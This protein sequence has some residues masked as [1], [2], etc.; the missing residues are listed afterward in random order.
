MIVPTS[1]ILK[2]CFILLAGYFNN[3]SFNQDKKAFVKITFKC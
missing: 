1:I 2:Y 3:D